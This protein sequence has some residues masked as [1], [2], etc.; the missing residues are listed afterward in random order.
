MRG[1]L[2]SL[3]LGAVAAVSIAGLAKAQT[4]SDLYPE[5]ATLVDGAGVAN[6]Q[7]GESVA[8]DGNTLVVGVPNSSAGRGLVRVFTRNGASWSLQSTIEVGPPTYSFGESVALDGDTLAVGSPSE[9]VGGISWYGVVRI[10]VRSGASWALQ[11]TLTLSDGAAFDYFG[12]V[13]ALDG[14]T[15]AVGV[16]FDDIGANQNAGSVR[17]FTRSG[18]TWTSE[19]TLTAGDGMAEDFFG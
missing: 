15:L 9:S 14:N 7:Y 5:V 8:L 2:L 13:L 6:D 4:L 16:N 10:F 3:I 12:S 11:A 19:A 1:G 17:I 18:T